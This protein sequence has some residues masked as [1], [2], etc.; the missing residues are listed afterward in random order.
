MYTFQVVA[1]NNEG[2]WNEEGDSLII[3]IVPP[4]YMTAWFRLLLVLAGVISVGLVTYAIIRRNKN[5][6]I[7]K[8]RSRLEAIVNTEERERQR[9]AKDLHDGVGQLLSSVKMNLTNTE[10]KLGNEQAIQMLDQSKRDIDQIATELRNI[11]Y[12][13]LPSSLEKFGLATAIEEQIKKLEDA[14]NISLHFT[15]SVEQD[16]FDPQVEIMLYR[17][18]QEMLNNTLKHAQ[19]SEITVQLLQYGKELQLMFEDNGKGFN[20]KSGL[21]QAGSSGLKNLYSRV[22]LINGKISID[23]HPSSGTII[24]VEVNL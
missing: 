3:N 20:L 23:S 18:F 19:A 12:N 6:L 16:R 11:S 22:A 15:N 9:I 2:V 14:D 8:Q 4:F 13:L 10:S 24:I 17:L 1:S 7:E 5:Q 21:E